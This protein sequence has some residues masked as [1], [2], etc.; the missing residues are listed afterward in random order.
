[1]SRKIYLIG[2]DGFNPDLFRVLSRE[3]VMPNL[4]GLIE[5]G[6]WGPLRSTRPPYTG[7]AWVTMFTGLNPGG[8][9]IYGFTGM[10]PGS[11]DRSIRDASRIGAER[12]WSRLNRAGLTAGVVN[13]PF[14]YPPSLID[15]FMVS[16]MLT[17][18][19]SDKYAAPDSI[20]EI[21]DRAA[22]DYLIDVSLDLEKDWRNL[23]IC[24]RLE[25]S[26]VGREA[27][28]TA[29]LEEINPDFLMAVF[30][31][32]DRLQ[33]LWYRIIMEEDGWRE[34]DFPQKA[35]RQIFKL[36]S[37][38][39]EAIGRLAGRLGRDDICMIASDHG[40]TSF[41]NT[42]YLN[43]W[44][45]E[46]GYLRLK[47][48]GSSLSA[49]AGFLNRTGLKRL[50]PHSL[51]RAGKARSMKDSIDWS[52]TRAYA[53]PGMEEGVII[54]LRGRQL[55]GIVGPGDEYDS[56]RSEIRDNLLQIQEPERIL[57][58]VILREDAYRGRYTEFAP[59]LLLDFAG[60]GWNMRETLVGRNLTRSYDGLPY[61]THQSQGI[62]AVSGGDIA[63]GVDPV[64]AR[65]EDIT[66]TIL[67]LFGLPAPS[68][69]DGAPIETVVSPIISSQEDAA[70]SDSP[71]PP[72]SGYS[73]EDQAEIER[74]L[75]GLG[76]L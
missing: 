65:I 31:L 38:L 9:G 10:N 1:M 32:P 71:P 42:F 24:W 74:R 57:K 13:V 23:D 52:A 73:A 39:D 44:L 69:L 37:R 35:R 5:R 45:I 40:F 49:L 34:G 53:S 3:G 67:N 68:S 62:W 50:V 51:V 58:D 6:A 2:L 4:S 15:G 17:P 72:A 59:D 18:A 11:Y 46:A 28:I 20:R 12:I 47:K 43:S 76:Y 27:V 61:G 41:R 8:H 21:I 55:Q 30:V 33:H 66:P 26:L 60:D 7:P 56:L 29:L 14:T 48:G 64:P 63:A 75:E 70:A 36:F 19:G 16:G 25:K 54:N 22:R